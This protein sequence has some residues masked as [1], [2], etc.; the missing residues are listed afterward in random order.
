[1]ILPLIHLLAAALHCCSAQQRHEHGFGRRHWCNDLQRPQPRY[2]LHCDCRRRDRVHSERGQQQPRL[3]DTSQQVRWHACGAVGM[4]HRRA[5]IM[6][7]AARHPDSLHSSL[8]LPAARPPSWA[9]QCR[10]AALMCTSRRPPR[11]AGPPSPSRSA[12]WVAPPPW[13]PAASRSAATTALSAQPSARSLDCTRRPHTTQRCGGLE[14]G[15]VLQL[16]VTIW[17][18]RAPQAGGHLRAVA[19]VPLLLCRLW[20]LAAPPAIP[21]TR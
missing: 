14:S 9:P 18:K 11:A 12:R 15:A 21:P 8:C 17:S 10:Q 4:L 13:P 2:P 3:C 19:A 7:V 1:M 16:L 20:L 5:G 6:I